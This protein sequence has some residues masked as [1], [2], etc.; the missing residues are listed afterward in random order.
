MVKQITLIIFAALLISCGSK[1]KAVDKLETETKTQVAKDIETKT[2]DVVKVMQ[3]DKQTNDDFTGE[4]ADVSQ[5]AT[6]TKQGNKTT[7]TNFKHVKT[8]AKIADTQTDTKQEIT[9]QI[10]DKTV[11]TA[12]VEVKAKSKDVEIKK[13]FPWWIL[14]VVA[15][16]VFI[17]HNHLKCWKILS[18]FR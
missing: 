16:L 3:V 14:I 8:A 17:V 10:A 6:I 5:P 15:A 2:K 12:S 11:T 1:K 13:G 9:Q 18:F 4:V 7:F